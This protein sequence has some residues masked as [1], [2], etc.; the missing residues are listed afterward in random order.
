MAPDRGLRAAGGDAPSR[1]PAP[2]RPVRHPIAQQ[3]LRAQVR[4]VMGDAGCVGDLFQLPRRGPD[5]GGRVAADG[6]ARAQQ[7]SLDEAI[8]LS[9]VPFSE[10]AM[11]EAI[12]PRHVGEQCDDAALCSAFGAGL[13][14]H[15]RSLLCPP[16]AY[17]ARVAAPA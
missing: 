1:G 13:L 5:V 4:L 6:Q 10:I 16:E 12:Q 7:C 3:L 11:T 2:P 9:G 17:P 14:R 8:L 15:F